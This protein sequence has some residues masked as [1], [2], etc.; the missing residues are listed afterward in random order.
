MAGN[1]SGPLVLGPSELASPPNWVP[2]L[3]AVEASDLFKEGESDRPISTALLNRL[4][5]DERMKRVWRELDKKRKGG[6]FVYPLS[7]NAHK[8]TA[9]V[10]GEGARIFEPRELAKAFLFRRAYI[11]GLISFPLP[12]SNGKS[13]QRQF[14]VTA[15]LLR[16][17]ASG[18]TG[19]GDSRTKY[20]LEV[21]AQ[22]FADL[23][24][25]PVVTVRRRGDMGARKFVLDMH[26]TALELFG[27]SMK[28]TVATIASVVFSREITKEKVV[29]WLRGRV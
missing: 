29:D 20:A 1:P 15:E 17:E 16:A 9:R 12:S 27:Q 3:V 4:L 5:Q 18:L 21:A 10:Y 19:E 14:Q 2:E 13:R 23:A 22:Y 24:A 6:G 26:M 11:F 28:G 7:P 25:L 8:V